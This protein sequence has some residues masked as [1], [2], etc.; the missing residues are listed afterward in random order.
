MEVRKY[1]FEWKENTIYQNV[2]D[3]PKVVPTVKFLSLKAWHCKKIEF[4]NSMNMAL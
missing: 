4:L 3:I 2:W 1:R